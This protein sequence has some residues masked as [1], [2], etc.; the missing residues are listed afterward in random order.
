M[1]D[2]LLSVAKDFS[3]APGARFASDGPA[4]GEEF[5]KDFL[6]PKFEIALREKCILLV[7]LDGTFGYATSFISESFGRLSMEFGAE[8]VV[9]HLQ[10]KSDENP[11][12]KKF[13][14]A[15]IKDPASK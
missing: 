3:D 12:I 7:D 13:S 14:E 10:I 2:L 15:V 9:R 5:Y 4:S 1:T 8:T 6:K 11:Y